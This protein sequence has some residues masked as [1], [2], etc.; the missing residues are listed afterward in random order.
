MPVKTGIVKVNGTD[1]RWSIFRQPIWA[2]G[3]TQSPTLLGLAILVESLE[4]SRRELVLEFDIDRTRHGDMP[5]HQRFRIHE[6]RLIQAI[7]S[8]L[9]AGWD[10]E[11]R[12]KRFVH[13]AGP[14]QPR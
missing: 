9:N 6:G 10:P 14:I 11:S 8:A 13:P 7:E 12:G 5:Q 2:R 1:Y 3:R 4:P